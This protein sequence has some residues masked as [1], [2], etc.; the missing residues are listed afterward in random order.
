MLLCSVITHARVARV[1][2]VEGDELLGEASENRNLLLGVVVHDLVGKDL[3]VLLSRVQ[4]ELLMDEAVHGRFKLPGLNGGVVWQ[5]GA[6]ELN[7]VSWDAVIGVVQD[8]IIVLR[9]TAYLALGRVREV[10]GVTVW[11]IVD[12]VLKTLGL[13]STEE[14]VDRTILHG[15]E[16][17]I[18][19]LVL[20]VFDGC[21]RAGL[22]GLGGSF[23]G[24]G[25]GNEPTNSSADLH[26]VGILRFNF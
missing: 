6:I 8:G 15:D 12:G 26:L 16:D 5:E 13:L 3:C 4:A 18:L 1:P 17:D 23:N 21:G 9:L 10:K 7:V 20:E 14:V 25:K 24:S 22:V 19:D 11:A 2:V